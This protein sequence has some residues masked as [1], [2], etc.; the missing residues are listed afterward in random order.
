MKQ[1][2]YKLLV[3]VLCW[4]ARTAQAQT[5]VLHLKSRVSDT[6]F[7]NVVEDPY[8]W[9]EYPESDSLNEWLKEQKKLTKAEQAHFNGR[10]ADAQYNAG[11]YSNYHYTRV[12]KR[13]DRFFAYG[14]SRSTFGG[15]P[16]LYSRHNKLE[17]YRVAF[18]PNE[19]TWKEEYN[20]KFYESSDSGNN[21]AVVL[22][23]K[24]SEW[25]DIRMRDLD[26]MQYYNEFI[27]H[28]KVREIVWWKNG[29][30]YSLYAA[31]GRWDT[32]GVQR[33]YYHTLGQ[34]QDKD[35]LIATSPCGTAYRDINM[36]VTGNQRYLMMLKNQ[37]IGK[38]LYCVMAYKDLFAGVDAEW[39]HVIRLPADDTTRFTLVDYADSG[40]LVYS[41]YKAP[42]GRVLLAGMDGVNHFYEVVHESEQ[43]IERVTY[44][45]Q[46]LIVLYYTV[47]QYMVNMYNSTG[48]LVDGIRFPP[49]MNVWGF[50]RFPADSETIFYE[51]SFFVPTVVY[52]YNFLTKKATPVDKTQVIF[53]V[54]NYTTDIIHYRADDGTDIPMFISYKK[55]LPLKADNPVVLKGYGSFGTSATPYY[56][57]GNINLFE[58]GGILA[59]PMIRG[60]GEQGDNWHAGGR[61]L[62]KQTTFDD[63]AAAARYLI[64]ERY[65]SKEHLALVG[66]GSGGLL[67]AACMV[68]HPD[69][70]K[71]VVAKSGVYDMLRYSK[72]TNGKYWK[73]EYG[74]P[75]N[76]EDFNNLLHYSPLHN[77]K[78][79]VNYPA[80]LLI[81]VR[82]EEYVMPLHTFKFL[83]RLQ[84]CTVGDNPH[85]LYFEED[86]NHG[87]STGFDSYYEEDAFSL[88][89]IY[90][91]MHLRI[92]YLF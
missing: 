55:G 72:F 74:D 54:N 87:Q 41:N 90:T 8:R 73:Q 92:K 16:V 82:G 11:G 24:N 70:C 48:G 9:M 89:F 7:G 47:G 34:N 26:S 75:D 59:V 45:H 21:L 67:A 77:L 86:A 36:R 56:S 39:K 71:V 64:K 46:Q 42:N 52:R 23:K 79:L 1:L 53:D 30:F 51:Q 91:Q 3:C 88:A 76:K 68:Q 66:H 81:A 50:N 29:F 49:G 83:A 2:R 63:F 18:D 10:M 60:G 58:S 14:H 85:I 6:I 32:T 78:R 17:A 37:K 25:Q 61:Q 69:L 33:V 31:G 22:S 35:Q 20:I 44:V 38:L 43:V 4:F 15:N 57:F 28:G 65:T 12:E 40:F 19:I 5:D 13:G 80:T 62:N 84:D 27:A